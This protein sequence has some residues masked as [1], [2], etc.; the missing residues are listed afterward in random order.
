MYMAMHFKVG[1]LGEAK[2]SK[3]IYIGFVCVSQHP[4]EEYEGRVNK[5]TL[6]LDHGNS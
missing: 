6:I 5:P 1:H 2:Q 3:M 4:V